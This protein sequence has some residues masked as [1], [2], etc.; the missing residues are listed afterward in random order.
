MSDAIGPGSALQALVTEPG[1][2]NIGDVRF[3]VNIIPAAGC[4]CPKCGTSETALILIGVPVPSRWQGEVGWC[5]N[6]WRPY[7]GIEEPR[8]EA[9]TTAIPLKEPEPA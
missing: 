3:V 8:R 9:L 5:P 4:E 1:F 6:H 7:S 2:F